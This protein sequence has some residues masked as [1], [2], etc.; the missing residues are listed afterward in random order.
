MD[1]VSIF[2]LPK[3]TDT[4]NLMDDTNISVVEFMSRFETFKVD[5][6]SI[7]EAEDDVVFNAKD[8]FEETSM[9]HLSGLKF[10]AE[11]CINGWIP[12]TWWCIIVCK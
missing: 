3:Y 5:E 6:I 11:Y 8:N 1:V 12:R 4:E 9:T 2:V 7:Q 10:D